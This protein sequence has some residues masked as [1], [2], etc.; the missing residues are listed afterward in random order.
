MQNL[1]SNKKNLIQKI[2]N[3]YVMQYKVPKYTSKD[4][5]E[6]YE[7][8]F[9]REVPKGMSGFEFSIVTH[10][11]CIG[12]CNFCICWKQMSE[13]KIMNGIEKCLPKW[14]TK[15]VE[16]TVDELEFLYEKYNKRG[17]VF[18]DDTWN[19]DPKWSLN[20]AKE[21]KERGIDIKWFGFMRADLIIRDEKIGVMEKI[22][23]SGLSHVCV[24]IERSFDDDLKSL[25]KNYSRKNAKKCFKILKEKYPQV[26]RQ[27]T[28]IV[29]LR[30]ETKASMWGQL[31]FARELDLDYPAFH[32]LTPI[33]GTP[34]WEKAKKEGWI[35]IEDFRVFDWLT[36][37]ISS[38]YL[39]R[40]EIEDTLIQMNNRYMGIDR[41]I[42]GLFSPYRYKRKMYKWFLFVVSRLISDMLNYYIDPFKE[43]NLEEPGFMKLI[44]PK[45][46]ND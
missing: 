5:D 42:K 2:D 14:R 22:V 46:Y 21:I 31:K 19:V 44:K 24:G 4:L 6:Y 43:E 15:S 40:E 32:P 18:T 16:K 11:G 45:W 9:K 27:G 25:N 29:G 23:D 10:R 34:Y 8:R 12:N 38:E 26:F 36:P 41:I 28:F 1:L 13:R 33:P 30:N 20:F 7:L 3:R 17:F 37:V 39:T 35:E